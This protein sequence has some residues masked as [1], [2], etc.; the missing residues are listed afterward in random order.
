ML[1]ARWLNHPS[2]YDSMGEQ[3]VSPFLYEKE[4]NY[5]NSYSSPTLYWSG[6]L[7]SPTEYPL[8]AWCQE[9][10]VTVNI[11]WVEICL[12]Y[13]SAGAW[14]LT[15]LLPHHYS[16]PHVTTQF[17][18]EAIWPACSGI[19]PS[20]C[21]TAGSTNIYSEELDLQA[22]EECELKLVNKIRDILALLKSRGA[23]F[24]SSGATISL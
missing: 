6:S 19:G 2:V 1:V 5:F 18:T 16:T 22:R 21:N 10:L 7:A 8:V 20:I 23:L 9:L 3:W 15:S 4:H 17:S 13:S 24:L 11:G 12:Q 14:H